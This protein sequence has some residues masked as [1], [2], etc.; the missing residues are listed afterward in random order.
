LAEDR[1]GNAFRFAPLQ[2]EA[3]KNAKSKQKLAEIPDSVVV[4]AS[5]GTLLFRSAA[6]LHIFERLGGIWRIMAIIFRAIPNA[7]RDT[8]YDFVARIR[9]RLFRRPADTCPLMPPGIRTRFDI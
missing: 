3:F 1:T 4:E 5:N 8:G 2:S 9:Y 6:A 7:L